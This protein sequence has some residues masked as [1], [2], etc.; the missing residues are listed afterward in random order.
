MAG[1]R[2][3][4]VLR[5]RLYLQEMRPKITEVPRGSEGPWRR[6]EA[7]TQGPTSE[8]A[9]SP[10]ERLR[11][12]HGTHA[13][14]VAETEAQS[15]ALARRDEGKG[16]GGDYGPAPALAPWHEVAQ[17]GSHLAPYPRRTEPAPPR[18]GPDPGR[19]VTPVWPGAGASRPPDRGRA[20][21]GSSRGVR[22]AR[23]AATTRARVGEP[24]GGI[25]ERH[26]IGVG[27]ARGAGSAR[28]GTHEVSVRTCW[29]VAPL[30]SGRGG[31]AGGQVCISDFYARVAPD[32]R[33][34]LNS[35]R[36]A[37]FCCPVLQANPGTLA[38][39]IGA[40]REAYIRGGGRDPGVLG[41]IWQLQVEASALELQRSRARRGKQEGPTR[42]ASRKRWSWTWEEKRAGREGI[43]GRGPPKQ[44]PP[45]RRA[46][47]PS[48]ELLVVE[49]ENRRLEAEILA[50]QM[51]RGA[52]PAPWGQ[53]GLVIFYDFLRGLEASWIWVQLMTGLARDGQ[54]TGGTTALPPALCLPPPPAPGPMGN[55]AILASRQPVPRLPPSPSVS[56]V[57]ELHA[58]QG[59]AWAKAPQPKAWAS[60][61]LFDRDQ[62][63]LSGHWRL[64]LR[65][66]PLDSSLSLG[67]LNGIPQVSVEDG[68]WLY[69]SRVQMQYHFTSPQVGQAELF[70]RLVNARDAGVQTLAEINPASA[71]KYQYPPPVSS[72]SSLEANS[73]APRAGFVDPPPPA[74][75]PLSSR[76][77]ERDEGLGPHGFD[78]PPLA[79]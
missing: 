59:L 12:L 52:G 78:P 21:A 32:P 2:Y 69:S 3:L 30:R 60:L 42:K 38:A 64:P 14:R 50:L 39:E 15:R 18:F 43:F 24:A 27:T 41:Q 75:E 66:L 76:V 56:L 8:A 4:Q 11:A 22:G 7:P 29:R 58:S 55:C 25:P 63:V 71:H 44:K 54:N 6:S 10:G 5:L 49:A 26:G 48:G 1:Y 47:A 68:D 31:A 13:R 46:G 70:L 40:L 74:E 28:G 51:Q 19:D 65:A 33:T 45:G 57:C 37:E 73:L 77:K 23:S 53:A 36:E 79:F 35:L 62:R 17:T 72:S 67:Q 34:G 61:V 16:K 9:G 20:N